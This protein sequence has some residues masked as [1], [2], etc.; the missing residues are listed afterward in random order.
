MGGWLL[1]EVMHYLAMR[2]PVKLCAENLDPELGWAE[3][4]KTMM[5]Q[6]VD[7]AVMH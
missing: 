7:L 6:S 4:P 2:R 1:A 3:T 5:H